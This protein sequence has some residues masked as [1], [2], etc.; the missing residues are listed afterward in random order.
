MVAEDGFNCA[1]SSQMANCHISEPKSFAD[2]DA[3]EWFKRFDIC[4]K[5]RVG[6]KALKLPTLLEGEALATW[7]ELSE[8]QQAD[9]ETV[10]KRM[11]EKMTREI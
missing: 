1:S 11:V 5:W 4:S 6:T 7:L 2:G 3:S 9:Y 8:E 10:K